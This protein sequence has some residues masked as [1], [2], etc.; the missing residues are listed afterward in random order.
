MN[1]RRC[2]NCRYFS[3]PTRKYPCNRCFFGHWPVKWKRMFWWQR[4]SRGLDTRARRRYK[5]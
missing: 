1:G 3:R 4:I 2:G 5:A